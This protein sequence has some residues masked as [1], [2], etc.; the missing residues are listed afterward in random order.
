MCMVQDICFMDGKG[1][2]AKQTGRSA[3][4]CSDALA[5]SRCMLSE[6]YVRWTGYLSVK[7][8]RVKQLSSDSHS[9]TLH[10]EDSLLLEI[11]VVCC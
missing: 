9:S 4:C 2:D 11:Q 10:R 1:G 8:C 5:S 7:C 6:S 3:W